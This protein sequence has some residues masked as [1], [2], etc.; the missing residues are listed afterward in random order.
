MEKILSLVR[1]VL[2]TT[3]IY[4]HSLTQTLPHELLSQAPAPSQWS[5][6]ECLQHLIDTERI[7]CF[8]LQCLLEGRDFP[9]FDP[10]QAGHETEHAAVPAGSRRRVRTAARREPAGVVPDRA[11]RPRPQSP[12]PGAGN[13]DDGGD[14]ARVGRARPQ[15]HDPGRTGDHAAFYSR[16][17]P[18]EKY[19]SDHLVRTEK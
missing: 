14:G 12:P 8:R 10:D 1:S 19:F 15:P 6:L 4:W 16:L 17:R 7:F 9:A 11:Q 18:V 2:T 13:R 5:A 3:P